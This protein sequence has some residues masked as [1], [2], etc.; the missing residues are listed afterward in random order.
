MNTTEQSRYP[1]ITETV[2]HGIPVPN[3]GPAVS[4]LACDSRSTMVQGSKEALDY[5]ITTPQRGTVVLGV[6]SRALNCCGI[7]WASD[8]GLILCPDVS[9]DLSI[10]SCCGEKDV[11]FRS[12][13]PR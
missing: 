11:K 5:A 9:I 13:H 4:N 10:A 12:F 8:G 6:A 3:L 1:R 2:E 7:C